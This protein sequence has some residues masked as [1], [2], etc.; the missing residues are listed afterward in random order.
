MYST[1]STF[2]FDIINRFLIT[3]TLRETMYNKSNRHKQAF[4]NPIIPVQGRMWLKSISAASGH[5]LG[6]NHGQ[7]VLASWGALTPPPTL[8]Q[9]GTTWTCRGIW[10]ACLWDVGGN[11][12]TQRKPMHSWGECRNYAQTMALELTFS[13]DVITERCWTKKVI[14]QES[15]VTT[16]T[17]YSFLFY[18]YL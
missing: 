9:T 16:F 7:D 1:Y 5:H 6:T 3:L 18:I 17:F 14:I 8:T 2:S 13:F 11:C 15:A 12:S 10:H 4:S